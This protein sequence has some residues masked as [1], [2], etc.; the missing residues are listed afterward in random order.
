M[1]G[2]LKYG[3]LSGKT[4]AMFGKLLDAENYKELMQKKNVG[5]IVSYLKYD[6][7]YNAILADIDE[8]SIHRS[9]LEN[10][11][12]RDLINDFAKLLK[13]TTGELKRFVRVLYLKIEIE[14]LK[15]IFR[16]FE[17]GHTE[18]S[19]LEDSLLFLASYDKLNIPKLA[20]SRNIEEFLQG[21]KGT[22]YYEV[23]RPYASENY[24]TRLFS[25]EMALDLY[26]FRTV[27][28]IYKKQLSA[29]DI[30]IMKD[31]VC[32]EIDIFNIFWIYRAKTYYK[33]DKEVIQSYVIKQRHKLNKSSI[34]SLV[35]AKDI[36]DFNRI[37]QDTP[38]GFLF[39]GQNA[40]M[41]EHSYDEYIYRLHRRRFRLEP[42]SIASVVSYL[43]LKE[44]EIS[45]IISVIEGIRYKLPE[46]RIQR[47]VVGMNA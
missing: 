18:Q 31:F 12:K 15:L 26:Y 10:L 2:E 41:L 11:L 44:I 20:L 42:F 5:E 37:I 25:M 29:R 28:T 24:V 46:E 4:R 35:H 38:Y 23:L 8:A 47:F 21:L 30:E 3:A 40:I 19:V 1:L 6:T 9:H 14:S 43:R 34:E 17:A 7:H 27:Q 32:P 39:E 33:I 16:V 22:D 36:E 45:N 13:F